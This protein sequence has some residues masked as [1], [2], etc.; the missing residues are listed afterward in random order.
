MTTVLKD[1]RARDANATKDEK[2][3]DPLESRPSI[4]LDAP[5]RDVEGGGPISAG[6]PSST[7][8]M[9]RKTMFL[10]LPPTCGAASVFFANLLTCFFQVILVRVAVL[11][12]CS[13]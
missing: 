1:G 10:V 9:K 5:D 8:S 4:E 6:R 7:C 3:L 2:A 12:S 11:A 13:A